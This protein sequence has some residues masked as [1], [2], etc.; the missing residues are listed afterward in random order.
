MRILQNLTVQGQ[1]RRI[2]NASRRHD[3]LISGVAVELARELCGLDA[4]AGR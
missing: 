4:D 2:E 1:K 3:D